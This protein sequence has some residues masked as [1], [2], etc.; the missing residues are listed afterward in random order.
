MPLS[1][2]PIGFFDNLLPK[3]G[4]SK[5]ATPPA[6]PATPAPAPAPGDRLTTSGPRHERFRGD[7]QLGQVLAGQKLGNGSI[8]PAVQKVQQALLDMA[9][10][11]PGGAD[12]RYGLNTAQGVKNF[13]SMAGLPQT[14]EVDAETLKALDKYAPP[15]GKT[16]WSEGADP[17]P[18]PSPAV[19][20]KKARVVVDLSQHRLF[21][22]DKKGNLEKIYGVRSGREGMNTAAGVKIVD[23]KNADPRAVSDALWPDSGGQAF[24]TRLLNLSDYDPATGRVYKGAHSGQELHGTYQDYSIGRDFSHGCVGL[25]NVDIEEIFDKLGNGELVK[26]QA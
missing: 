4:P 12:G 1:N 17:G 23:G 22:F 18:V 19:G 20:K 15:A 5:P 11:I 14:G 13:Q 2:R 3:P 8:G 6:A 25:R 16:S 21:L 24:G 9:F 26:F 7:A 10:F